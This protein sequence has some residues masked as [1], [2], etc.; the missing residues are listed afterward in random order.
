MSRMNSY[1]LKLQYCGGSL[2]SPEWI[3]TAAHCTYGARSTTAF[4]GSKEFLDGKE[5]NVLET[6]I[7]SDWNATGLV[8]NDISLL[9]I[10][11]ITFGPQIGIV[12]LPALSRSDDYES[13]LNEKVIASGWGKTSDDYEG[14]P[15]ELQY[16]PLEIISNSNCMLDFEENVKPTTI[17]AQGQKKTSI[18]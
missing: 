6:I 4:I 12:N 5:V 2:I 18:C 9:R 1:D 14:S 10:A 17:C 13:C 7:H 16:T 8:E 11:P 15:V 3:V